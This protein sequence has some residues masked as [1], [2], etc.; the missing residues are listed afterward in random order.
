MRFLSGLLVIL[1][2][3]STASANNIQLTLD[4]DSVESIINDLIEWDAHIK[5]DPTSRLQAIGMTSVDSRNI[6]TIAESTGNPAFEGQCADIK[7]ID[8]VIHATCMLNVG[9]LILQ[10]VSI[11]ISDDNVYYN[12]TPEHFDMMSITSQT[13]I[14]VEMSSAE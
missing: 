9:G 2:F 11:G 1:L 13:D 14:L 7:A 3:A 12:F 5:V 10:H 4:R 8:S 6:I